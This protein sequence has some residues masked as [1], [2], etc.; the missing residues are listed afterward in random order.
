MFLIQ[1]QGQHNPLS[2]DARSE[3]TLERLMIKYG[4]GNPVH[5]AIHP[6]NRQELIASLLELD[7][8]FIHL[9]TSEQED[10]HWI[11]RDNNEYLSAFQPWKTQKKSFVDSTQVFYSYTDEDK[12]PSQIFPEINKKPI[13][14][15]FY[16]SPANLF[17]FDNKA[18]SIRINPIIN[19]RL[20]SELGSG[21]LF[22]NQRGLCIKGSIN[23]KLFFYSNILET[24][25]AFPEYINEFIQSN[26]A[27]PGHGFYKGYKS[28]IFESVQGYDYLNSSG[29][30][31][32]SATKNI[33]IN[34]GHGKHK[35][36]SGERSMLL[37]DFSNN[38]LYLK[39]NTR[40]W[41]F[42]YQNLFAEL[43]A[44]GAQSIPGDKLLP[45]KYMA[46]HY[47]SF[48]P[49]SN[50]EIGVFESIVFSRQDRRFEFQYLNP[51]ILYRTVEHSIGSP[52]NILL[53]FNA[54][55]HF[56]N[57]IKLYG[58]IAFDEFLFQDYLNDEKRWTKKYA[59]QLGLKYIN[60]FNIDQL[61]LGLEFNAIRPYTFAHRD[62]SYTNFSHYNQALVHPMGA[63]LKEGLIRIDYRPMKRL[64]LTAY[65]QS[66]CKGLD[67]E[68]NNL[69]GDIF[70][71]TTS[72]SKT[73]DNV[74]CQ[75]ERQNIS[76]VLFNASYAIFHNGYIDLTYQLRQSTG[77][78]ANQAH[79][80][81]TGFRMN[82]V[83]SRKLF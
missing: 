37:S 5:N 59:A 56:F 62:S 52:D 26:T 32:F 4:I 45:K 28:S 10:I 51:V 71:P 2:I 49:R 77:Q 39:I 41:K 40:I 8:I 60:V 36:G 16:K 66:F 75:G 79:L 42:H 18:F 15:Y 46:A 68:E 64:E 9:N 65:L 14:K 44:I 58:Q 27:I 34:F 23:R 81:T 70:K 38:Y 25:Q 31:S 17:E 1:L 6:I 50:I 19:F 74:F 83:Q 30:I 69:G 22:K 67:G 33:S 35:I 13:L 29:G 78:S 63:N 55:A 76:N 72:R 11:F 61:D 24:Q 57:A 73:F 48:K 54:S 20:G 80:I 53:G 47:L 43:A 82:I 12:R 7:S 21:A 3:K